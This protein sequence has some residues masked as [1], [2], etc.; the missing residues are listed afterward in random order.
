MNKHNS[1]VAASA[2]DRAFALKQ[3]LEEQGL[4]PESYVEQFT[5]VMENDF[6]PANG[7]RVVA[8][9]WV[10]PAYRELLL[11]DGTAA[12]AQFGYT[13]VQGEYIVALENTP[14]L[15]NVIVC[16]LC[17]C[18]AWPV[19]GLPPDW[20][21]SFEYRARVVRE[22]RSVLRE[23]GLDLPHEVAIR[24]WDTSAETRYMVL[25][26]RPEGT[27]GWSE[28]QLARLVTK[29]VLIGIARPEVGV[30]AD[31]GKGGQ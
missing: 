28:E 24:V 10:D 3:A 13:G 29:D 26:F 11:R 20:Y 30:L 25:P 6:D 18:T 14:T 15:Q 22:S 27:E 5:E 12:C 2:A 9:A 8:R 4:L 7:A 21:K 23:M 17:S 1:A 16:T 31:H 19:L